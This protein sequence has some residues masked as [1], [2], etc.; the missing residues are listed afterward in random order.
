MQD[1]YSLIWIKYFYM[2]VIIVHNLILT[3]SLV[4]YCF[5]KTDCLLVTSVLMTLHCWEQITLP[6]IEGLISTCDERVSSTRLWHTNESDKLV[7]THFW[8]KWDYYYNLLPSITAMLWVV[9]QI[10]GCLSVPQPLPLIFTSVS[11]F[12]LVPS[13]LLHNL[14]RTF[15]LALQVYWVF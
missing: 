12:H 4:N 11:P 14:F 7:L 3:L 13:C 15:F 8:S 9:L 6:W 10:F 1:Y 2:E 5:I